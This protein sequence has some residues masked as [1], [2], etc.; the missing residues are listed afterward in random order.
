MQNLESDTYRDNPRNKY[1]Y[2]YGKKIIDSI[3]A[4]IGRNYGNNN[5][6][7]YIPPAVMQQQDK[8]KEDK[9]NEKD[10]EIHKENL[11]VKDEIA[12]YGR[13]QFV[14][15]K[16]II[17]LKIDECDAKKNYVQCKNDSCAEYLR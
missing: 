8:Q 14:C 5:G 3:Q 10:I 15:T 6:K 13:N 2:F 16:D 12:V 11:A 1:V 7:N 17:Q 4:Q 9:Q